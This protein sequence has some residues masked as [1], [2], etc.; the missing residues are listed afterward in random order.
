MRSGG[1]VVRAVAKAGTQAGTHLHC[2]CR[3]GVP[4]HSR[5]PPHPTHPDAERVHLLQASRHGLCAELCRLELSHLAAQALILLRQ[6][7]AGAAGRVEQCKGNQSVCIGK[8][9]GTTIGGVGVESESRLKSQSLRATPAHSSHPAH[10]PTYFQPPAHPPTHPPTRPPTSILRVASWPSRISSLRSMA[11]ASSHRAVSSLPWPPPL[12]LPLA[13]GAAAEAGGWRACCSRDCS[14]ARQGKGQQHA[15]GTGVRGW[16][17]QL[18][19]RRG[20]TGGS[21]SAT[22]TV[23]LM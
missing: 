17:V 12:L 10:P 4:P 16:E 2:T 14:E 6:G 1:P 22:A 9:A 7:R 8:Y 13:A 5:P 20:G 18:R 19:G 21:R 11:V 23:V 3:A 15:W